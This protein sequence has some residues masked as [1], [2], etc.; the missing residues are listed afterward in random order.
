MDWVLIQIPKTRSFLRTVAFSRGPSS[1]TTTSY[2]PIARSRLS[3]LVT[4]PKIVKS[5]PWK[6]E[7]MAISLVEV[8]ISRPSATVRGSWPGSSVCAA[9]RPGSSVMSSAISSRRINWH[10]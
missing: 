1:T 3:V 9:D 7:V 4:A 2:W 10:P 5:A 8:P 6:S